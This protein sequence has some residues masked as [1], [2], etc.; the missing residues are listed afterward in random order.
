MII[1]VGVTVM[2]ACQNKTVYIQMYVMAA[3][4]FKAALYGT[5]V[6]NVYTIQGMSLLGHSL[7][8]CC[9]TS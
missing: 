5:I 3:P 8:L 4:E 7:L 9:M 6:S 1:D 2:I